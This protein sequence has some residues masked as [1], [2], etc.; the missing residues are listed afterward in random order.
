MVSNRDREVQI[1]VISRHQ[2]VSERTRAFA[3]ERAE[4]L[5]RY[6][7]RVS[8]VQVILEEEHHEF[9]AEMVVHVAGGCTLVSRESSPD[10]FRSALDHLMVKI[11][12][13]LKK[14]KEKRVNHKHDSLR[15]GVPFA[16]GV[17]EEETYEDIVRQNLTG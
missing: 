13:Q 2:H 3:T 8:R 9:S 15:D 5:T 11:E 14:D 1:D 16:D 6:N 10:G 17:G 12:R 4:K 7:D